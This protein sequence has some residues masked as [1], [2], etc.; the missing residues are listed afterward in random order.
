MIAL[1]DIAAGECARHNIEHIVVCHP[2]RR[3]STNEKNAIEIAEAIAA[4][5]FKG[6]VKGT[7]AQED[8]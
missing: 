5:G 7:G 2:S 1:G 4:L 6:A 3:G 8:R